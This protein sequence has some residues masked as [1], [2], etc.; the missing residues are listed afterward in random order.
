M[1]DVRELL[2]QWPVSSTYQ[3]PRTKPNRYWS[4][5][6]GHEGR[7]SVLS[8]L[9]TKGWAD[10]LS[11]GELRS[12]SSFGLFGC[13]IT[14][15]PLG[16]EH[17]DEIVEMVYSYIRIVK[18]AGPSERIWREEAELKRMEFTLQETKPPADMVCGLARD[19]QFFAPAD[20]LGAS[21][22]LFEYDADAI[23]RTG[24]MLVPSNM[25]LFVA[26]PEF[27]ASALGLKERW[28]QT[29]YSDEPIEPALL[30]RWENAPPASGLH[31]PEPNVFIPD[32]LSLR[33]APAEA[34]THPT[35]IRDDA[36]CKVWHKLDTTFKLPRLRFFGEIASP[37]VYS[38]PLHTVLANMLC[39]AVQLELQEFAYEAEV[40]G[41]DYSLAA[42]PRGLVLKLWG[43]NCKLPLLLRE[44]AKTCAQLT[45]SDERF[46]F[47][48]QK[49]VVEYRNNRNVQPYQQA[50]SR[51]SSAI[52]LP[53]WL[54][55]DL[56]DVAPLV[57]LPLFH[58]FVAELLH[59]SKAHGSFATM[60]VHG[61]CTA[62]EAA[63]LA[64]ALLDGLAVKPL[65]PS[66]V[67]TKRAAFVPR[68]VAW[69][70]ERAWNDADRNSAVY[71]FLQVGEAETL[72][73]AVLLELLAQCAKKPFFNQLRTQ[74]QLGYLIFSGVRRYHRTAGLQFILQGQARDAPFMAARIGRWLS[75]YHD[76][77]R[78]LPEAEFV[79]HV[80][81]LQTVK[82][83]KFT[84]LAKEADHLWEEIRDG[85]CLFDR[86]ALEVDELNA[87]TIADLVAFYERVVLPA[88][89]EQRAFLV[90]IDGADSDCGASE[91]A[92]PVV[93]EA[94]LDLPAWKR[95]QLVG[96]GL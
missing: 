72:R 27:K 36:L 69:Y 63:A 5:L 52:E 96:P 88:S 3:Q 50:M 4:H 34:A 93:G 86:E 10:R 89:A 90:L 33:P 18:A 60:L 85:S 14:L 76:T 39:R 92:E 2:I 49:V 80:K 79:Q 7:G 6:L 29:E 61:N 15:S 20:V 12:A 62:A 53:K 95:R 38:S 32:D 94:V 65:P 44:I 78:V 56:A 71:M 40:A 1:K 77:L 43:I 16:L 41:L 58:A 30:R 48:K 42:T 91:Q 55:E 25:R 73:T 83:E 66:M 21:S 23:V 19:M 11:A 31:L 59:G 51:A 87:L 57:T 45:L 82:Q 22:L 26:A 35:L 75:E 37:A 47:L 68:G 70:R 64:A 13:R 17:I 67:P 46:E 54:M 84:S 24:A 8:I 81:A 74:E 9:K 28:Y